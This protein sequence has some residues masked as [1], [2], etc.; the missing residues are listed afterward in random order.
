ME[1]QGLG[2][3]T[4]VRKER[5]WGLG[6]LLPLAPFLRVELG[7]ETL[8]D[9]QAMDSHQWAWSSL[10]PGRQ[11]EQERLEAVRGPWGQV[12]VLW[13]WDP[14][15]RLPWVTSSHYCCVLFFT[16]Q[17]EQYCK[18]RNKIPAPSSNHPC[19]P[20]SRPSHLPKAWCPYWPQPRPCGHS[21]LF[22][23][24]SSTLCPDAIHS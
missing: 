2:S 21:H 7:D 9:E 24:L 15:H 22:R 19:D 5:V 11:Q 13:A 8:A 23:P 1:S 14:G 6:G 17:P 20:S 10:S 12:T 3:W 16:W 4:V 18:N